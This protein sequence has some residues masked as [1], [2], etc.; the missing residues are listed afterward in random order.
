LGLRIVW[1]IL[2][3][4]TSIA[5]DSAY[6]QEQPPSVKEKLASIRRKL[7]L[8]RDI[9]AAWSKTAASVRASEVT[10]AIDRCTRTPSYGA[11]TQGPDLQTFAPPIVLALLNGREWSFRGLAQ[12]VA[13]VSPSPPTSLPEAMEQLEIRRE[14]LYQF[15]RSHAFNPPL[16]PNWQQPYIAHLRN[17]T[18]T[19]FWDRREDA[20]SKVLISPFTDR[21]LESAFVPREL[22]MGEAVLL[23]VC[24]VAL[25]LIPVDMQNCNVESET[26]LYQGTPS[27]EISETL[28]AKTGYIRRRL[29]LSGSQPFPVVRAIYYPLDRTPRQRTRAPSEFAAEGDAAALE[30]AAERPELLVVD[31]E[32]KAGGD[33]LFPN[34]VNVSWI[35]H[36]GGVAE[37][38]RLKKTTVRPIENE[39][40]LEMPQ[41]PEGTWILDCTTGEQSLVETGGTRVLTEEELEGVTDYEQLQRGSV[42]T[43]LTG[44]ISRI[45]VN[46]PAS[47]MAIWGVG[48][49]VMWMLWKYRRASKQ[50]KM[51]ASDVTPPAQT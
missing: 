50:K 42:T 41:F 28:A 47:A 16:R 51:L 39:T 6:A 27:V 21:G 10:Y 4:S 40:I 22:M 3:I 18:L 29:W 35:N 33:D 26:V 45:V 25:P 34:F 37:F 13:Y 48:V 19:Q 31:L 36:F 8:M 44:Y 24:P 46:A 11:N 14:Y 49:I 17:S 5:I 15:H 7:V 1:A 32:R 43:T 20:Y 2:A 23:G 9:E 38:W 12:A 30:I